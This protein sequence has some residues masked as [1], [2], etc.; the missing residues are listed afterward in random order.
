MEEDRRGFFEVD[1]DSELRGGGEREEESD[2]L[3]MIAV[4]VSGM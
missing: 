3:D 4:N 2:R 1:L